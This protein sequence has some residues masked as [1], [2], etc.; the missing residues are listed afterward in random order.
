MFAPVKCPFT[1]PKTNSATPVVATEKLQRRAHV[2]RQQVGEERHQ[3]AGDVG[4]ADCEGADGGVFRVRLL[5]IEFEAHQE[6]DEALR[7]LTHVNRAVRNCLEKNQDK[8]SDSC[9]Q[10]LDTT[11]P[12]RGCGQGGGCGRWSNGN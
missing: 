1:A 12:G 10:A 11:G 3:A 6:I 8:A 5:E 4:R 9:R 7:V 2:V